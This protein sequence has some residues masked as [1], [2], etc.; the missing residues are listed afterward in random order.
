MADSF[1]KLSVGAKPSDMSVRAYNEL[2]DVLA[3][4]KRQGMGRGGKPRL[5]FDQASIIDVAN[6]TGQNCDLGDVLEVDNVVVDPTQDQDSFRFHPMLQGTVPATAGKPVAIVTRPCE[7]GT[8]VPAVLAGYA[9]TKVQIP[10]GGDATLGY[11]ES[12]PGT[13]HNLLIAQTGQA[14]IIWIA[15]SAAAGETGDVRW[16]I[17]RL[18]KGGSSA[19][20]SW[21]QLDCDPGVTSD[22]V[23]LAYV[24]AGL[25]GSHGTVIDPMSGCFGNPPDGRD[26]PKLVQRPSS[27]G[28]TLNQIV[29]GKTIWLQDE[30]GAMSP[31]APGQL[32]AVWGDW[33]TAENTSTTIHNPG[34]VSGDFPVWR[35]T[36]RLSQETSF[37]GQLPAGSF[38]T[39]A[40]GTSPYCRVDLDINI[41]VQAQ[42]TK[43]LDVG[44]IIPSL[45]KVLV[46]YSPATASWWVEGAVCVADPSS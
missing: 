31:P 9:V 26:A 28:G 32:F 25:I 1:K 11:A 43:L 37:Y 5:G 8:L 21:F 40:G 36:G 14:Q 30:S 10:T 15:S 39:P 44:Q 27:Q 41:S 3:W 45:S 34:G 7:K 35:I 17:V 29:P 19:G 46:R 12:S 13:K 38:L 6:Q 20:T 33:V 42:Q 23:P 18:G 24:C 16:A 4:W 2:L 22:G